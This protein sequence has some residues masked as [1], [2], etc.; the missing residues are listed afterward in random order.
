M[1]G[2]RISPA[3]PLEEALLIEFDTEPESSPAT[4]N[5]TDVRAR[6]DAIFAEVTASTT[7]TPSL[8]NM[9]IGKRAELLGQTA[10]NGPLALPAA[11]KSL[12][13]SAANKPLPL[14]A[15][16]KP[17]NKHA[18]LPS[19]HP[20]DVSTVKMITTGRN[21]LALYGEDSVPRTKNRLLVEDH[22]DSGNVATTILDGRLTLE[23][24]CSE[25]PAFVR[26]S[27]LR[28]FSCEGWSSESI[29]KNLP[30]ETRQ[31]SESGNPW[32][33]LDEALDREKALMATAEP[34][35]HVKKKQKKIKD[36]QSETQSG[37]NPSKSP[38]FNF[39]SPQWSLTDDA[40]L[41]L[42]REHD[43]KTYKA[44]SEALGRTVS[45]C[46][47]RYAKL[48]KQREAGTTTTTAATQNTS[49]DGQP[50]GSAATADS[51][52]ELPTVV[53]GTEILPAGQSGEAMVVD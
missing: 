46:T 14:P 10:T 22:D 8:S 47:S 41:V 7:M 24:I 44:I 25:Y 18:R 52:A 2:C 36:A 40:K 20:L 3:M 33:W 26:G 51:G 4:D 13:P 23:E 49:Q 17:A 48:K 16:K 12:P 1:N 50:S 31:V 42:L 29:W 37:S 38:G 53:D 45:A 28:V 27:I 35:G 39:N 15:V 6:M 21:M 19:N 5:N 34:E 9:S 30:S 32:A 11:N 43:K